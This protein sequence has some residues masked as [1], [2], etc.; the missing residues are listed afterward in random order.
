[1]FTADT[2]N[3]A[4]GCHEFQRRNGRCEIAPVIAGAMRGRRAG[5]CNR[6]VR[7]GRH[8]GQRIP[9]FMEQLPDLAIGRPGADGDLV[10][11]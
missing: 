4:I 2:H 6:D 3:V 5:A 7:Q 1:M 11:V 9:P 8:V 10:T